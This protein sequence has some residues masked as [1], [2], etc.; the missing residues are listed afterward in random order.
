[1]LP[2]ASSQPGQIAAGGSGDANLYFVEQGGSRIG[3]WS[4]STSPLVELQ[5]ASNWM[6]SGITV[7]TGDSNNI[8]FTENSASASKVGKLTLA[9]LNNNNCNSR[10]S[11]GQLTYTTVTTAPCS[12]LTEFPVSSGTGGL[13]G[14]AGDGN[15]L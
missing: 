10:I 15:D 7:D 12:A 6:A 14:I 3:R 11:N 4:T 9:N 1:A 2:T 13:R 5:L 8:Y